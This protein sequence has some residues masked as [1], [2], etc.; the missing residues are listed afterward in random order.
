[1]PEGKESSTPY[2]DRINELLSI[3]F[4]TD[5]VNLKGV[6]LFKTEGQETKQNLVLTIYTYFQ[7]IA[8]TQ[9]K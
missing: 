8:M 7:K 1:V 6:P 4:K 3:E 2:I 9:N 5:N